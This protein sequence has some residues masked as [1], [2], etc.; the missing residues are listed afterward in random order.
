MMFIGILILT[1]I[2]LIFVAVVYFRNRDAKRCYNQFE[3]IK[4]FI[5]KPT[6]YRAKKISKPSM[7]TQTNRIKLQ[8]VDNGIV[9]FN[10]CY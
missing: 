5:D 6:L 10:D 4:E 7:I 2:I 3:F 8:I 1:F 9:I